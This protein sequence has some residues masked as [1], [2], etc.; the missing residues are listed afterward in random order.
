MVG[1]EEV[2]ILCVDE[3]D[4]EGFDDAVFE[5]E[6]LGV[7]DID[8]WVVLLVDEGVEE[9]GGVDD[10]G[11]VVVELGVLEVEVGVAV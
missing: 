3:M 10:E 11:G 4:D 7:V 8:C 6:L 1:V 2:S 5:L 9:V